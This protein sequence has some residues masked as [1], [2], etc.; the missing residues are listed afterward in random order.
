MKKFRAVA[1]L[2]AGVVALASTPLPT[3]SAQT[4]AALTQNIDEPGRNTFALRNDVFT[5]GSTT[6]TVPAGKRYVIDQYTG[7][8]ALPN[9]TS[10]IDVELVVTSQ[11]VAA[12][13]HTPVH[14]SEN[15]GFGL[16]RW[17]GT[18]LGPIYADPGTTISMAA[19]TSVATAPDFR[20]CGFV[21]TGHVINNP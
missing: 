12:F 7:D 14:Y 17:A 15:V 2:V 20:G 3:A 16:A 9:S 1:G 8:C 11:G 21:I 13:Y 5:G 18:G 10:V 4:R 19:S 6:F